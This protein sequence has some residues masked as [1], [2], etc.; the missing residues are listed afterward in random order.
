MGLVLLPA[1]EGL[2]Q[3]NDSIVIRK[4]TQKDGLPSYNIRK[5]IQD[6][7]GFV[8]IASQD[9]ISRFDGREFSN[10][11]RNAPAKHRISGADV[12]ELVEDSAS[13]SLWSIATQGGINR[14][15]TLTGDVL[16]TVT[17][18]G[19]G[20]ED[21]NQS[22]LKAKNKLWI[23]TTTG[24]RIFDV[25]N[26]RFEPGPPLP[27]K[28]QVI[29]DFS[30]NSIEKDYLENI[31]VCY[32]GYGI[33]IYDGESK[34][35]K[36]QIL[37]SDFEYRQPMNE[38]QF[39]NDI[40]IKGGIA[41]VATSHGLKKIEFSDNYD[42]TVENHP[43]P[44]LSKMDNANISCAV[45]GPDGD[46]LVAGNEHLYTLK[47][48]FS[49]FKVLEE[50]AT[51]SESNWL[52]SIYR[53]YFDEHN[54][55][56]LA[57]DEGLGLIFP[58]EK[59]FLPCSYDLQ[60]NI[61]LDHVLFVAPIN[62]DNILVGLANGLV[63]IEKSNGKFSL[64]DPSHSYHFIFQ[65]RYNVIYVSRPD[66]L[67]VYDKG[68]VTPIA[69]RYPEFG[70]YSSYSFNSILVLNDSITLLAT[71]NSKGILVWN[72]VRRKILVFD[73]HS[74]PLALPSNIVNNLFLDHD[75]NIWVL[76]DNVIT[77]LGADLKTRREVVLKEPNGDLPYKLF[78]DM[79]EWKGHFYIASYSFGIIRLD[80]AL[81]VEKVY[82]TKD[83]LSNDGVYQTFIVNEH[84][85]LAT[86][87]NG[88]SYIDL[89][90][91]KIRTYYANDGLHS[92]AFEEASGIQRNGK[93]YVGG[94]GGFTVIN[95]TNLVA[96]T[97]TPVPYFTRIEIKTEKGQFDTSN[98][99]IQ[100]V[101][102][103]NDVVQTEIT[104]TALGYKNSK[105]IQFAY[106]I[107]EQS[108]DWIDNGNDNS[109]QLVGLPPDV[110]HLQLKVANEEEKWSE[111]ITLTLN[112]RPKWYQTALF[113]LII[114]VLFISLFY[115]AYLY[116]IGQFKREES[117]RRKIARDLH[118]DLGS[119]LNGV[120]VYANLAMLDLQ[121]SQT[122]LLRI[123][124]G[125]QDA[126][127]GIRDI[128]WILDNKNDDIRSLFQ[129]I[130]QFSRPLCEANG[131]SYEETL[132]PHSADYTMTKEEKRNIY[133][134]VKEA[135]NNSIKYSGCKKITV[136]LTGDK[137]FLSVRVVD[138]GVGFD[139]SK[140]QRGN[141]L[142]NI[143]MRAAEIGFNCHIRSSPG[144]GTEIVIKKER[145]KMAFRFLFG[146]G[147]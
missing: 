82:T 122:Y 8:W 17:V 13:N 5:I 127:S 26:G 50:F 3:L 21:W 74:T 31:W 112:Y 108:P 110:Y 92:N 20:Y 147:R 39:F 45:F 128:I 139:Q 52:N 120:K 115:L 137:K 51:G 130:G 58:G 69:E 63:E 64:R 78:F 89:D 95:P 114:I 72:N 103:P 41:L 35:T 88:L 47:S 40:E 25:E 85:L 99:R 48:D 11:T 131:I 98:L 126:I 22:M 77:I 23:G 146:E 16:Q 27:N 36:A 71:E 57:C 83:G 9:G 6:K 43:L 106:R 97:P 54:N 116:R 123:K 144:K 70:R 12:R 90:K 42:L 24:T 109:I 46:I 59:A 33:V 87:N 96:S 2:G 60:S 30:V 7:W 62:N 55:I 125:T 34:V 14:I 117:I 119:T 73:V 32:E 135:I 1:I 141:G 15:S 118:D 121:T 53:L 10:Y 56:W 100:D 49:R 129:R 4:F 145:K 105:R 28:R 66:G 124:D 136:Q 140:S 113:K 102:I 29:T 19:L 143:E 93:I 61:K 18:P 67:F 107:L 76:S 84:F 68:S 142:V 134:I 44:T 80:S 133:M 91:D 104:F 86:S 81:N 132:D 75:G 111:P 138:D 79:C 65:D 101:D 38:V 37:L 94:L